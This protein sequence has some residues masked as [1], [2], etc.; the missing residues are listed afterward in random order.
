M[1][2]SYLDAFQI[3]VGPPPMSPYKCAA[4]GRFSAEKFIDWNFQLDWYGN[5]YLCLDCFTQ[6]ANQLQYMASDQWQNIVNEL[7][8]TENRNSELEAENRVLKDALRNLGIV[9]D[10]DLI[11]GVSPV[12]EVKEPERVTG[13][14]KGNSRPKP[15]PV[16]QNDGG[17]SPDVSGD[18]T[19]DGILGS[20]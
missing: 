18:D 14:R 4:C 2:Y 7:H 17:G 1:E 16:Q 10:R 9:L 5:V 19:L 15:R 6:C 20:I 13:P 11:P 3:H 12:G 8:D